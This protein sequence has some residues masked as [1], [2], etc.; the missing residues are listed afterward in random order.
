MEVIF[1]TW[2]EDQV[3]FKLQLLGEFVKGKLSFLTF[4]SLR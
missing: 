4:T 3:V 2:N 1:C